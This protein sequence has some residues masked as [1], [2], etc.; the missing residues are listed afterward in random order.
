MPDGVQVYQFDQTSWDQEADVI[1]YQFQI[2]I[3]KSLPVLFQ[4]ELH[5]QQK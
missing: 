4:F 2:I 1:M 5:A 3:K